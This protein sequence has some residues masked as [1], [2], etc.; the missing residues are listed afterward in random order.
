MF[1]NP[2]YSSGSMF[3]KPGLLSSLKNI[4]WSTFKTKE[5]ELL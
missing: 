2:L 3:M 5:K 1:N 4:N